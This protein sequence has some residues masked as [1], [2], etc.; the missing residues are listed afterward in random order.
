MN[1]PKPKTPYQ[2]L[3][4]A[5]KEW[6]L[7]VTHPQTEPLWTYTLVPL[8]SGQ[9]TCAGVNLR[10]FAVNDGET[11]TVLPG[12]LTRV[13]LPEGQLVVNSSQGGGSKDTW[14]L[15]APMPG[16]S[17][18]EEEA[19]GTKEVILMTPPEVYTEGPVRSV[20]E[21]TKQQ[22]QAGVHSEGVVSC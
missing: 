19:L 1:K 17:D 16:E 8:P 11:I 22:Q 6:A 21:Q 4:E 13:A 9:Y 2:R 20:K 10:P 3:V 7:K 15:E 12:G 18:A 5:S 14:V